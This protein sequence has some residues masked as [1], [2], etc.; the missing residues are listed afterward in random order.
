MSSTARSDARSSM[1]SSASM[2]LG[3]STCGRECGTCGLVELRQL[4]GHD[5]AS[6]VFGHEHEV[7]HLDQ[8]GLHELGE[9]RGDI[10]VELVAREADHQDLDRPD[11]HRCSPL[12]AFSG[13]RYSKRPIVR[14][15]L[16]GVRSE[17]RQSRTVTV[18]T[19]ATRDRRNH[20]V[21]NE[22]QWDRHAAMVAARVLGRCRPRVRGSDPP[23][24]RSPPRRG[25]ACPRHRLRRGA[26]RPSS[27]ERGRGGRGCRSDRRTSRGRK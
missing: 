18:A 14:M 20:Q 2:P 15:D 26:G 21:E 5:V 13:R 25:A 22:R 9:G 10:A 23:L 16:I 27:G 1:S 19:P 8:A 11:A 3:S 4:D 24:G 12:V 6:S 7:D 17:W